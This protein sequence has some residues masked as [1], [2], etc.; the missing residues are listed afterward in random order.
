MQSIDCHAVIIQQ[1]FCLMYPYSYFNLG[2]FLLV[3][4]LTSY[5]GRLVGRYLSIV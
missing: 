5:F 2:A 1:K 4:Y 3:I